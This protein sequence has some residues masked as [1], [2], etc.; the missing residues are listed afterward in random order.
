[1]VTCVCVIWNNVAIMEHSMWWKNVGGVKISHGEKIRET[2]RAVGAGRRNGNN[3][4]HA[5]FPST[6]PEAK[7][8]REKERETST[9]YVA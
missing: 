5:P 3:N 2:F 8:G 9:Q 1:M 7:R 6:A 4:V